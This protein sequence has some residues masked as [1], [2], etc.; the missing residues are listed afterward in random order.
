MTS[1]ALIHPGR[2]HRVAIA[3]TDVDAAEQWFVDALGAGPLGTDRQ[4]RPGEVSM[5]PGQDDLEGS[6]TALFRVGG[7]PFIL[8]SRGLPGGPIANFLARYG[9]GV[10]S[11][12]WEVADMWTAQNLLIRDGIRIAAV[13]IPGRHFF[14]HPKDTHG[15]LMEWT[16]DNFGENVTRPGDP[17]GALHV[18]G[19]AWV[20]AVVGDAEE[21]AR[22]LADLCEATPVH[23]NARG[24]ADREQV[25]DVRI[26]D[27]TLRLVTPRSPD[28]PYTAAFG[29]GPR[30]CAVA[31]R[32]RD[33][34]AAAKTLVDSGVAVLSREEGLV[35]TDPSAT[36]GVRFEWTA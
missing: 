22:F 25:E 17:G 36:F 16:D 30:L 4:G 14:M 32:V 21:T 27:M 20:T 18:Q 28:S 12:A 11:L 35:V 33:P 8:L 31:L 5:G 10:H 1:V 34:E 6:E 26:G 29:K 9:P 24:P 19:L 15:V 2:L 23:G 13:N 7:Y 3:V